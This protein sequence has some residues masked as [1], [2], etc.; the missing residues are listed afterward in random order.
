MSLESD[1]LESSSFTDRRRR[2]RRHQ[3]QD[4]DGVNHIHA[5]DNYSTPH[6]TPESLL[7]LFR[8]ISHYQ[9][10]IFSVEPNQQ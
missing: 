3:W 1:A 4:S 2:R 7:E 6:H 10:Q 8:V 5:F 9:I